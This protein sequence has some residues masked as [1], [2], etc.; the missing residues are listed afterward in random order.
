MR[1]FTVVDGVAWHSDVDDEADLEFWE[2]LSPVIMKACGITM[3]ECA[4]TRATY[5][6]VADVQHANSKLRALGVKVNF[7]SNS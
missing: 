2:D 3:T 7:V 1:T 5:V 4:M 6:E